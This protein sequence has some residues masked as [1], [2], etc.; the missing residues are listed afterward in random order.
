MHI[1]NM[2]TN[3]KRSFPDKRDTLYTIFGHT[4][5][6]WN[7]SIFHI[8]FFHIVKKNIQVVC[9]SQICI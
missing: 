2:C 5:E 3:E 9:T 8:L 4:M 6:N 1:S 7:A